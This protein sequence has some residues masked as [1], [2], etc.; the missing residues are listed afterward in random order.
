MSIWFCNGA[1]GSSAAPVANSMPER[2][3]VACANNARAVVR[4][5]ECARL[6]S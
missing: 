5:I 3:Y 4:A 2:E 1:G 6:Q